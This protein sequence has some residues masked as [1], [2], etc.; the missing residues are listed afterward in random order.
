MSEPIPLTASARAVYRELLAAAEAG[1]ACPSNDRIAAATGMTKASISS[2]M[3]QAERRGWIMV[4]RDGVRRRVVVLASGQ[5]TG[6]GLPSGYDA[7]LGVRRPPPPPERRDPCWH[8]GT[9]PEYAEEFGCDECRNPQRR[10]AAM[11]APF[12]HPCAVVR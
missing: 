8:C 6:W 12:I 3:S 4:V 9:R 2:H 11:A 10:L 5:S 1:A 7:E